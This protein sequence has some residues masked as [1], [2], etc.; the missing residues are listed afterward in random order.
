MVQKSIYE[1]F[2]VPRVVNATGTKTRIGGSLIRPEA[3]DAMTKAASEFVRLSDLQAAA[4]EAFL[5]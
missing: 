3:R 5:S 1:Q 4:S 2:G